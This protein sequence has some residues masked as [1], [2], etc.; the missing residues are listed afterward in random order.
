MTRWVALGT[1]GWHDLEGMGRTVVVTTTTGAIGVRAARFKVAEVMTMS[2]NGSSDCEWGLNTSRFVEIVNESVGVIRVVKEGVDEKYR[3]CWDVESK[4][5]GGFEVLVFPVWV[6]VVFGPSSG[7]YR[8]DSVQV[9]GASWN[10][11]S[12]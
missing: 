4:S 6:V 1:G 10:R 8:S 3:D 2:D 11:G 5:G 12:R 9:M 7:V